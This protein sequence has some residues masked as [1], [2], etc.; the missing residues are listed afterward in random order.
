MGSGASATRRRR[1]RI[2]GAVVDQARTAKHERGLFGC[3]CDTLQLVC[4]G[5]R[6]HSRV[7]LDSRAGAQKWLDSGRIADYF[8]ALRQ[9]L[10]IRVRGTSGHARQKRVEGRAE[11][12]YRVEPRVEHALVRHAT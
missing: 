7:D 10:S 5:V 9:G 11:Q 12:Y 1:G 2:A 4:D 8:V 6:R 3:F